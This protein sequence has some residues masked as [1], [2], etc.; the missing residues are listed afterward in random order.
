MRRLI[1]RPERF[2]S[3]PADGNAVSHVDLD[4]AGARRVCLAASPRWNSLM[5]PAVTI[6]DARA[7]DAPFLVAHDRHVSG[8]VLK[9]KVVCGQVLVA[10]LNGTVVGWLR[11]GLLWDTIPF[12]N[13]LFVLAPCHGRGVGSALVACWENRMKRLGHR[14]VLTSTQADEQA[15]HFYRKLGYA[16]IGVFTLPCRTAELV[17][18]KTFG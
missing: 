6:D 12:M 5:E 4:L 18:C 7:G 17:L 16:D 11:F 8:A 15:Q 14:E 10:R 3:S 9:E 13:L 2:L 1:V